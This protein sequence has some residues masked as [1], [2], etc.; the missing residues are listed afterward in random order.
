[1]PSALKPRAVPAAAVEDF[2]NNTLNA[3]SVNFPLSIWALY[4]IPNN[5]AVT[6]TGATQGCFA[7]YAAGKSLSLISLFSLFLF[8]FLV[9]PSF[10]LLSS[11]FLTSFLFLPLRWYLRSR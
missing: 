10:Y 11:S 8:L 3:Y 4:N 1:M 2:G 5:T 6:N 7:Q 9:F